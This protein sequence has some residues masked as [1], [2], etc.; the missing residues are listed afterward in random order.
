MLNPPPGFQIQFPVSR[1]GDQ[2]IHCFFQPFLTLQLLWTTVRNPDNDG[3]VELVICVTDQRSGEILGN[4]VVTTQSARL[5]GDLLDLYDL[6]SSEWPQK[7]S[8]L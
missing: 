4:N 3:I 8:K 7:Q 6:F 5:N 2:T 1:S